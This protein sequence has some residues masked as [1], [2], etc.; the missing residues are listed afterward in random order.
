MSVRA[1]LA[2]LLSGTPYRAV[3]LP[4]GAFRIERAPVA[5]PAPRR[6]RPAPMRPERPPAGD[7]V[8]TASKQDIPL[9]RYPG[10]V[11]MID[12]TTATPL[13]VVGSLV[14][15]ARGV[16]VL[17]STQLGRGRNKL[18]IRGVADSSFSGSTQ[19][20][21]SIYLDDVQLT[22]SG[23]DPGLRLYDIQSVEVL[24]GPQ[25]TLYG[26]GA[27][28]G[29]IRLTS[30][31]VDLRASAAGVIAG[32]TATEGGS[33][34]TDVAAMLNLPVVRERL[35]VRALVYG[36]RGGGYIHDAR[37]GLADINSDRTVG[38]RLGVRFDTADGWR[39]EASGAAQRI[40]ANDGQYS[41]GTAGPLTRRSIIA[42]PFESDLTFGRLALARRWSSGLHLLTATGIVGYHST[43][44]FDATPA[45]ASAPIIYRSRRSKRLESHETRLS[46]TLESGDSWVVG[47][48][49][50]GDRDI[51]T[52]TVAGPTTERSI[53]GV[54]NVTKSTS[55]FGEM[56][57]ALGS[58][59]SLTAGARGT[60]GR[61]DGSPS[62]TP[63]SG[64]FVRGRSTRRV[65][66]TLAASWQIAS[67]LAVFSRFQ[68]G[69]RTGGLSVAP[70][71]GRVA[72]YRS[73]SITVGEVGVRHVRHGTHGVAASLGVSVAR[74]RD[75]Q[76]DLINRRGLPYTDNLG[77]A[78][79]QT[80][81]GTLDWIP[82]TGFQVQGAFLLTD[83][84]VSGPVA[85]LSSPDNRRLPNTP[86]FAAHA[87]VSYRWK[88]AAM[89]PYVQAT[90]DYVGR[91]VLGTGDLFD[92]SQGDYAVLGMAAGVRV[93]GVDVSLTLDNLANAHANRFAFG[94]PFSFALRDQQTPLRPRSVRL[95]VSYGW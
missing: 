46:R 33:L 14:D 21:T 1:A 13:G 61:T 88:S 45:T 27:I 23:P 47:V 18:F 12:L 79:I 90:G 48:T 65:D 77:D 76:A 25:G 50:V 57:V 36:V 34:G 85:D 70:G 6:V 56:T 24:E 95:G 2:K 91:S 69:Y 10:S 39:I 72:D 83:T 20:P 5:R 9:L 75:I 84:L 41:E 40:T 73:D 71:I 87:A 22:Y 59:L 4:S 55:V 80:L 29:V 32:A 64:S 19:S 16:P 3:A 66:P 31:P 81:E 44:Q 15:A 93:A 43:E 94:N 74:W 67:D 62:A 92:I 42:Q 28:G 35:G 53:I 54:T 58:S 26:S 82:L 11:T 52:R 37:R 7:V 78:R 38:G 30:A 51:L 49:I 89:A 17:Q 63:V 68:T 60:A 8:V 86:P